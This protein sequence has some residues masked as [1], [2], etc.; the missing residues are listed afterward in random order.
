MTVTKYSQTADA[1]IA[2]DVVLNQLNFTGVTNEYIG[3]HAVTMTL[4]NGFV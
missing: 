1:I 2:Y 3:N 4:D